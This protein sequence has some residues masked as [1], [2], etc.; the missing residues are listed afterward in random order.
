[1][2]GLSDAY[3][4][5]THA[6]MQG[7]SQTLPEEQMLLEQVDVAERKRGQFAGLGQAQVIEP[8]NFAADIGSWLS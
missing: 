1:V 7:L 2:N 6:A 5:E 4:I 3:D 8:Q